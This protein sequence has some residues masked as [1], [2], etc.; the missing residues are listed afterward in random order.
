VAVV[1]SKYIFIHVP[2]A[3]GQSVNR[4]LGGATRGVPEHAPLSFFDVRNRFTFG[5]ARNP[6]SRMVSLYSFICQ[7]TLRSPESPAYQREARRM[8]FKAWLT[9]DHFF[10]DQDK[11]WMIQDLPSMQRRPQ[12]FWLEGCDFIGKVESLEQDFK[13]ARKTAGIRPRLG[14]IFGQGRSLEHRNRSSHTD[15]RRYYDAESKTFV[16]RHFEMDIDAFK[17]T[18]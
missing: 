7:K 15:Y 5:F 3:A 2:K 11:N 1:T 10:M 17:Y 6:W 12:M 13:I 9:E 4:R 8:G 16:A 18:F 14:E